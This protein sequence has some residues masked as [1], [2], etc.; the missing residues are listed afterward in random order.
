MTYEAWPNS[1]ETFNGDIDEVRIYNRALSLAEI[2][3]LADLTPGDGK[4]HVPITSVAEI[5]GLEAEPARAI[6][7]GDFAVI[8]NVWLEEQLWP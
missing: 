8:A 1:P 3:Y 5:Y 7:L 4:Y 2:A 6:N